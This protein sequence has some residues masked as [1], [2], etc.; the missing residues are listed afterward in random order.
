MKLTDLGE[1]EHDKPNPVKMYRNKIEELSEMA[2]CQLR[3]SNDR[4]L[5]AVCDE[6]A[7]MEASLFRD[8]LGYV[9]E[10]EEM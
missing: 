9:L 10:L 1:H 4:I 6:E 7:H 2:I 5:S 3:M 8:L